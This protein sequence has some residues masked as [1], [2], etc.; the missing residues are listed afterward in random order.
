[1]DCEGP[2][3]DELHGLT[4]LRTPYGFNLYHEYRG[5]FLGDIALSPGG[6]YRW[7]TARGGYW[8]I[9]ATVVKA[10]GKLRAHV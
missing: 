7:A 10:K 6:K 2:P 5:N 1:M 4:W 3:R 9:E 8:G